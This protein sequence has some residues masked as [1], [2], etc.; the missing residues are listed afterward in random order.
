MLRIGWHDVLTVEPA[1][2]FRFTCSDQALP[3][4]ERNLCVRAAQ[5]LAARSRTRLHGALRLDKQLP[6]GAGLGGGSSDAAS[7]LRLLNEHWGLNVSASALHEIAAQLGSDVP[8]FLYDEPVLAIGRG[9]VLEPLADEPYSLPFA[10]TVVVPPVHVSTAEA[11]ALVRPDDRKRPDLRELVCSNDLGWW[12]HELV[13]DFQDPILAQ[14]P[15]IRD[16]RHGLLD[17]GAGY[18]ALSGSGAAVFGVFE[19][20]GDAEWAAVE[21][22]AQGARVWTSNPF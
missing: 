8:F 9:E 13:N 18:A 16:A 7:T 12:R 14:Y 17:A 19:H 22:R 21:A 2:G 4:D 1:E 6:Y 5:A 15:V 10:V 11:Y 3:T 20:S